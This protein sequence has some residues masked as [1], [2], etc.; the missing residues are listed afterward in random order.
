MLKDIESRVSALIDEVGRIE[1]ESETTYLSLGR[2][3]PVLVAEMNKSAESAERSL[4]GFSRLTDG[5]TSSSLRGM[6]SFAE[7]SSGFFHSIHER[8]SAFLVRINESIDRLGSL[9][10]LIGRVRSDSEEME[11]IS[12]NAMTVALKSGNAGKAFSVITDELKRLSGRTIGLTEEIT[13]RGRDLLVF[14]ARLRDSLGELDSFQSEFFSGLDKTLST[15]FDGLEAGVLEAM[16]VFSELLGGTRDLQRPI[17]SIMQEV[18]HQDIVRQSL[19]HVVIALEEARSAASGYEAE[20]N[21]VTG[22]SSSAEEELAYAATAAELSSSLIDDVVSKLDESVIT[23]SGKIELVRGSVESGE[24]KRTSFI[25]EAR[26][27]SDQANASGFDEG[28]ARYLSLKKNV[29]GTA[30]RLADQVRSLE[31]SFKGLSSLLSRFQ[32][33]V[34]A[35]RIEVAKNRALG[36]VATTVQGMIVLT[37]RIAE[38]VGGAMATTKDF[39]KVAS[40]ALTEY[41]VEE[42]YRSRGDHSSGRMRGDSLVR[43]LRRVESDLASLDDARRSTDEAI[44][45]FVLHTP[46]FIS[47]IAAAR[48]ELGSLSALV[49]RLRSVQASLTTLRSSA[50]VEL[51]QVKPSDIRSDRLQSMIERFTIFTHKKAAGS[52][53]NFVVEQGIEA[54]E[55]TL[56]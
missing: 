46:E 34:V 18:Q 40:A 12:L 14:F 39:I 20:G 37:D 9:E 21:R 49:A 35:S 13:S 8:D 28:S 7:E 53:G 1:R 27:S 15:G 42:D 32:N 29:I 26:S 4:A 3:F 38:D 48:D 30:R 33:I 2:L 31:E 56:F 50:Q 52:I 25:Q 10:A 22:Q 36:S 45:G 11:I 24:A 41:A 19:Q 47:L 54:G 44:E 23:F 17:Q 55:I 5:S 16:R 6:R 51:G 43:T